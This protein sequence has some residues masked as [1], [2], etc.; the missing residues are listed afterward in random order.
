MGSVLSLQDKL[1][2][3][4]LYLEVTRIESVH[5][6]EDIYVFYRKLRQHRISV[7]IWLNVPRHAK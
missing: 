6:T 7:P 3:R 2:E 4:V 5:T 1:G